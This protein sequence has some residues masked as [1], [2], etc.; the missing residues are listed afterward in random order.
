MTALTWQT[1]ADRPDLVG[2]QLVIDDQ[3]L[4]RRLVGRLLTINIRDSVRLITDGLMEVNPDATELAQRY[5]LRGEGPQTSLVCDLTD[6]RFEESETGVVTV[7]LAAGQL[8]IV[9]RGQAYV[10]FSTTADL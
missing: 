4:G 9:P 6:G 1:V 10:D 2:G 7:N 3:T 5:V 8:T